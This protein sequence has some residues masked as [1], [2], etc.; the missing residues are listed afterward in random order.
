VALV[1]GASR[2]I[3]KEIALA[4]AE[5]GARVIGTA[6]AASG[7]EAVAEMLAGQASSGDGMVLDVSDP[8]SVSALMEQLKERRRE[9][10]ILINNAGITRDN[11]LMRIKPD[12]WDAVINTNLSSVYRLCQAVVRSMLKARYGRIVNISSVVG[13]TGNA[14]QSNYAAAKAGIIGFT[15]SLARE[16]GNRGITVNAVA[17]GLIET[18]MTAALTDDQREALVSGIALGRLGSAREVADA[19]SFLVSDGAAYITGE[20]LN[21]N[22]GMHMV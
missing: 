14:G 7:A 4:L 3:G 2:G 12:D 5:N 11:L 8:A 6:T 19:V 18:D 9:P 22:G 13:L 10:E 21:V 16:V 20:T 15:K 1:T 17:P